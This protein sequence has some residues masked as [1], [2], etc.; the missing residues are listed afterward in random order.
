MNHSALPG[1][2]VPALTVSDAPERGRTWRRHPLTPWALRGIGLGLLI[3]ILATA[4]DYR[5][6]EKVVTEARWTY[7]GLGLA[8]LG[9]SVVLRAVVWIMVAERLGIRYARRRDH[10]PIF[11]ASWSAGLIIPQVVAPFSVLTMLR[12]DGHAWGRSL[13]TLVL[14]KVYDGLAIL[15]FG[16]LGTLILA[17]MFPALFWTVVVATGV[18][19]GVGVGLLGVLH[20][21][22]RRQTAR[23]WLNRVPGAALG[24]RGW[25]PLRE[26]GAALSPRAHLL[27]GALSLLIIFLSTVDLFLVARGLRIEMG[28]DLAV[29]LW[30]VIAL[31]MLLPLSING[32]GTREGILVLVITA[33]GG[34]A[35]QAVSLGLLTF[36]LGIG[37][38]LPGALFWLYRPRGARVAAD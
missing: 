18:G 24:L 6:L 33:E 1:E 7:V 10:L 31:T 9:F 17:A 37:I 13:V 20:D 16:V 21:P 29:G 34:T 28:F 5:A 22:G 30:G 23:T 14:I 8:T 12:Q 2:V 38:R 19:A 15:A 27:I 3:G 36:A 11:L 26:A 25:T 35:E 4:I 32:L